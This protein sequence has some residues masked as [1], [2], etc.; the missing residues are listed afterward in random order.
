MANVKWAP[1]IEF[2]SGAL[3]K[4]NKKSQHAVDQKMVLATHRV[5]PTTSGVCS[6]L[7]F[8]GLSDVTRSTQPSSEELDRRERFGAVAAMVQLRKKDLS[9]ISQ[10][11]I[12]FLAQKDTAGG[13]KT[14]LK[15][16]W[17]VCMAEYDQAHSNG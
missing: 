4:I 7:F 6:R 5:A 17:S 11:Q 10:D 9:K 16:L 8:R 2:V 14:M 1:G 13:C 3:K 15:Y 12:D